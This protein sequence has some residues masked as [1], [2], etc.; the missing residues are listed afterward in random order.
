MMQGCSEIKLHKSAVTI[1]VTADLILT[2][3]P[4]FSTN[5]FSQSSTVS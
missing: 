2:L 3:T 5:D 1:M 4:Y